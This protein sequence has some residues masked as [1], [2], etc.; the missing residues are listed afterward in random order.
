MAEF[1]LIPITPADA[2]NR[3]M[4]NTGVSMLGRGGHD[5]VCGHCGR[6]MMHSFDI[7]QMQVPMVYQCGACNG[8]N[9][10]PKV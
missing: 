8:F 4:V 3:P 6:K 1:V 5:Y 7:S 2:A 10:K 9:V